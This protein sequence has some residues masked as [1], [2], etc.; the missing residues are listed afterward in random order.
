MGRDPVNKTGLFFKEKL[1]SDS[2]T[3]CH[4]FIDIW[5]TAEGRHFS[6]NLWY[7]HILSPLSL[8]SSLH[9]K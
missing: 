4:G 8:P 3:S 9:E 7:I 6:P 2:P 5:E 1:N